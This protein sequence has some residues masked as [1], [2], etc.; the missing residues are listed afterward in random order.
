MPFR[1]RPTVTWINVDGL[2]QVDLI[3]KIGKAFDLHPLIL[4]DIANTNQRPK[5][6]EY[7][8]CLY[9]VIQMFSHHEGDEAIEAE[10]VSLV[11]GPNFVLSF[12]ERQGDVF[13]VV[14][15]RIR[16]AKGR[17][18]TMGADYLLYS[19]MD[20]IVDGYFQTCEE[21]GEEIEDLEDELLSNA[22]P[23][24]RRRHPP[25]QA[26]GHLPAQVRLAA[27]RGHQRHDARARSELIHRDTVFFLRDVYD[28]TI[29]VIDTIESARDILAGLLDIYLSSISNRMNEVMKVLTIIATVF[30]PLTFIAG[31]YGM[32]FHYMP[33]LAWKWSY[34]I[35]LAAMAGV[36]GVMLYFF[37]RKG[38]L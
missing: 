19:L 8:N 22:A 26:R 20:A 4:E 17:V 2:H 35:V 16:N 5:M 25:A 1:D 27:A 24:R 32:N 28:H 30:I 29:Q 6:E 23:A 18:R 14:R 10:Q 37:R 33:E 21:L 3:E 12:Q 36:A 31:V 38:W 11:L 34:P 7:S 9:V 15:D 13:D